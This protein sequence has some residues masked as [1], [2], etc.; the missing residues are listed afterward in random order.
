[1]SK[2]DTIFLLDELIQENK[3]EL[4][5]SRKMKTLQNMQDG[6]SL[7]NIFMIYLKD[8]HRPSTDAKQRVIREASK[9]HICI[10]I[11]KTKNE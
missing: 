9:S 4:Q 5:K 2:Q 3:V 6:H 7:Q 8:E 11:E 10:L 1:M